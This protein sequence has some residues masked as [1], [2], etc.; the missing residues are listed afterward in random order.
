[1]TKVHGY[2]LT[3]GWVSVQVVELYQ[4]MVSCWIDFPTLSE[5]IEI[6]S[7]SAWPVDHLIAQNNSGNVI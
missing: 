3:N 7:F 4:P 2:D 5:E 6:G 1:M